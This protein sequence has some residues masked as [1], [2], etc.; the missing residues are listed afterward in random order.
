MSQVNAQPSAPQP[1]LAIHVLGTPSVRLGEVAIQFRTRKALALLCYLALEGPQAQD[2]L[3]ELLWPETPHSGSLRTAA[4]HVRQALGPH[5]WRLKTSWCGLAFETEGVEL[6]AAIIDSLEAA[7]AL[8]AHRGEFLAGLYLRGN[9]A[10]DDYLCERGEEMRLRYDQR[11]E[12]L[13]AQA[14]NSGDAALSLSLATRRT[15]L[16]PLSEQA[17]LQ[18][19]QALQAAGQSHRVQSVWAAFSQRF[20]R[21]FGPP[22]AG[23]HLPSASSPLNVA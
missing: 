19:V 8:H 17:C 5:A 9:A 2:A 12:E 1:T 4:L 16:D 23:W 20:E 11:L 10:W 21:E 7:A 15:E 13:S 14:L 18:R 3:L 6:D 22:Q